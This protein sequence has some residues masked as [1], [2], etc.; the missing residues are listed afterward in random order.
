MDWNGDILLCCQDMYNRTIK[1]GNVI[2]KPIFE[3]WKNSK[4]IQF[5]KKLKAGDRSLS[6][7]NNCNANGLIFGH[8][9]AKLW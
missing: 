4:L 3:I 6:P 2:E 7:C 1:F 5:R 9:H 8:N